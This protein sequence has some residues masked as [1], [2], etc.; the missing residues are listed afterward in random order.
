MKL[1]EEKKGHDRPR[2]DE[3]VLVEHGST[4]SSRPSFEAYRTGGRCGT[5]G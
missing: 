3:G 5:K 2:R 1:G 4:G